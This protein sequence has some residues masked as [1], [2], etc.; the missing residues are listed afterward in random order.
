MS[1][2]HWERIN[3][4]TKSSICQCR[5]NELC[6]CAHKSFII[7]HESDRFSKHFYMMNEDESALGISEF[8]NVSVYFWCNQ[9]LTVTS[10][11]GPYPI[12]NLTSVQMSLVFISCE[13]NWIFPDYY[14]TLN[15]E[16]YYNPSTEIERNRF[17]SIFEQLLQYMTSIWIP[18]FIHLSLKIGSQISC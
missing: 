11:C 14:T 7:K 16:M 13:C 18:F 6:A 8:A 10:I 15:Y 17:S 1:L 3:A 5:D 2:E 9:Y 4:F 12:I